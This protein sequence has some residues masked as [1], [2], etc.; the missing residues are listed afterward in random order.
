MLILMDTDI[1]GFSETEA[2]WARKVV[3]KKIMSD[4][5]KLRAMVFE[6]AV[7]SNETIN[8]IWNTAISVQLG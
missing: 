8:Y 2:N 1:C 3:G 7:C 5:P 6:K 4:I